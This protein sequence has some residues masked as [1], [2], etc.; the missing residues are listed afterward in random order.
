MRFD[1]S[2]RVSTGMFD[3]TWTR[4]V[5]KMAT[6]TGKTKVMGLTFVWSYFH[7]L[8]EPE[9]TLS[10]NF[11]VIAPNIIVLNRLKKDFVGVN[12]NE[13]LKMFIEEP[14]IPDNGFDD[15]DWKND[16]QISIHIQDDL[17]PITEFGNIFLTNTHRVGFNEDPE[18]SFETT[19]LG[20]KPKPDAD[21]SK[22]LDL[23]KILRSDKI[24]DLVV[25]ND[26]AHHIHDSTLRWF[27]NIEEI[28]NKLK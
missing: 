7:K 21:T 2:Q 22:G 1:S 24:K 15:K 17:K 27:I 18:Q 16:F 9:S 14:F 11:L 10:R 25:L 13:P 6:G 3:E 20:V 12:G 8:Y 5:M 26:E 28:S 23:G 4:Y 19:F